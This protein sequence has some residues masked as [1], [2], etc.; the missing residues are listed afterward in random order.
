MFRIAVDLDS[1]T[2]KSGGIAVAGALMISTNW[3]DYWAGSY[4]EQADVAVLN[5]VGPRLRKRGCYDRADLMQVG[6]WKSPRAKGYLASNTDEMIRDI[7]ST[8]FTAPIPIQ[9]RILTLLKGV[10]VPMASALLMVWRPELHTV[11]D[12]RAIASLVACGE[13]VDPAPKAY[14]PYMD[15]LLVCEAISQRCGRDLRTLD[16]ALYRANGTAQIG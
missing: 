14:P 10:E 7:S 2:R 4:P 8:A 15:Y 11:I 5:V 3:I 9:H 1:T 6:A 16:R 13:I 12:V